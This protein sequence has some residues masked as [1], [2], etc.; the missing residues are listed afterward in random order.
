M[1]LLKEENIRDDGLIF[2]LLL[3]LETLPSPCSVIL[4][5]MTDQRKQI[6]CFSSTLCVALHCSLPPLDSLI[7]YIIWLSSNIKC[8]FNVRKSTH[9]G[10]N[11]LYLGS[12]AAPERCSQVL[13][14]SSVARFQGRTKRDLDIKMTTSV[15]FNRETI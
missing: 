4:W 13:W 1:D 15:F 9:W 10:Y 8:S 3:L 2:L 6:C 7:K 14:T 11:T 5:F 12:M